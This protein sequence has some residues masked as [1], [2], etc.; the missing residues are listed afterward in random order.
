MFEASNKSSWTHTLSLPA[1]ATLCLTF[2][3]KFA[4]LP[5]MAA[6]VMEITLCST[7]IAGEAMGKIRTGPLQ[8][9]VP[10]LKTFLGSRIRPPQLLLSAIG[11]S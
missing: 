4:S 2:I 8:L 3:H 11:Q 1:L 9:C 7:Q 10:L 6:E 5:K